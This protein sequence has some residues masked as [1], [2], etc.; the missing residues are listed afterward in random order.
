[1]PMFFRHP[2]KK[3]SSQYIATRKFQIIHVKKLNVSNTCKPNTPQVLAHF[4]WP[5]QHTR[6]FLI[7]KTS[8]MALQSNITDWVTFP[9]FHNRGFSFFSVS[10]GPAVELLIKWH[11]PPTGFQ[12]VAA[13]FCFRL[14][15][16]IMQLMQHFV[17][18]REIK[19]QNTFLFN[20]L[21]QENFLYHCFLRCECTTQ[22]SFCE[23]LGAGA[24][25]FLLC[26]FSFLLSPLSSF[27]FHLFYLFFGV[28]YSPTI[29]WG[30]SKE[31]KGEKLENVKHSIYI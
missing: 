27:P 5:A 9:I 19:Y 13:L 17:P 29:M 6:V 24:P 30:H 23:G 7:L 12:L 11:P 20:L 18:F 25:S 28:I 15:K 16:W 21:G 26:L 22:A 3:Q 14:F 1:M 10:S 2:P 8:H 4:L 31:S